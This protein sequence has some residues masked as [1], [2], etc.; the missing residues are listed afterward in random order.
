MP[1]DAV[2]TLK[3]EAELREQFV[4]EAEAAHRPASQVMRDLMRDFIAR[5]KAARDH[6]QWFR[7]EVEQA[8]REA[9]DPNTQ[10]IPH[11][12]V[13]KKLMSWRETLTKRTDLAAE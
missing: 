1:K 12:E 8:L 6:D 4:A 5:Q 13:S 7:A 2:F 11:D 10:W 9:D 3:L